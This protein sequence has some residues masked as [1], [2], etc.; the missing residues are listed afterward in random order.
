MTLDERIEAAIRAVAHEQGTSRHTETA[1]AMVA[2]HAAFP[3]LFASP[4]TH[5]LVP[6]IDPPSEMASAWEKAYAEAP[7]GS[8][9]ALAWDAAY[10]AMLEA[11]L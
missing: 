4:P 11:A 5:K 6:V 2:I 1:M 9:H 8:G 10:R 3:E 7:A